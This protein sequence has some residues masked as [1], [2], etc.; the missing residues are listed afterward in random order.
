M[1]GWFENFLI[2]C[3]IAYR[4]DHGIVCHPSQR[5]AI[6]DMM[7]RVWEHPD[8]LYE[9]LPPLVTATTRQNPRTGQTEPFPR[10]ELMFCDSNERRAISVQALLQSRKGFGRFTKL[11]T[12]EAAK[13]R[14]RSQFS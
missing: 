4:T 1:A 6:Q 8:W 13:S 10:D 2:Q 14:D 11:Y 5:A 3:R 9:G 7:E 12:P